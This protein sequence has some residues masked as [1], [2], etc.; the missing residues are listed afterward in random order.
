M[1]K[2]K[3]YTK[4]SAYYA[5]RLRGKGYSV[6]FNWVDEDSYEDVTVRGPV[7]NGY[8]REF[9]TP[10]EAWDFINER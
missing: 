8:G 9:N 10:K 4:K 7:F 5:E 6:R 2:V 3:K 1:P